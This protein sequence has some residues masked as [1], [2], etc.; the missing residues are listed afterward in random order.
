MRRLCLGLLTPILLHAG[1]TEYRSG[2]FNVIADNGA[3]E[4]YADLAW[5]QDATTLCPVQVMVLSRNRSQESCDP[6]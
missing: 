6:A 3:K 5:K 2:P 4:G 1:W